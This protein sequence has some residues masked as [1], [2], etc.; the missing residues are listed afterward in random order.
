MIL[1]PSG[2][3]EYDARWRFP[4]EIDGEGLRRLGSALGTILGEEGRRRIVTGHDYRSYSEEVKASLIE[5]LTAAGMHV[6]DIGLALSPT[7]YFAQ[8]VLPGAPALAMVTASHN[9][10]GWTGVKMGAC[11]PLTFGPGEMAKLKETALNGARLPE[12]TGGGVEKVAGVA[13]RY[14]ADLASRR[15]FSRRLRVVLACGNGTAGFFAPEVFRRL[16]AE[17]IE[18]DC[19]P[20]W[21]FPRHNP[22]PESLAMMADLGRAVRE[23]GAELGLAFDGDGDRCGFTDETGA[24]LWADKMGLLL[25]RGLAE[26]GAARFI[27][28][29]K[30]T[31]LFGRDPVLSAA[32]ASVSYWKTG[33]SYMKMGLR[34][35]GAAAGFEKSGHFF[36][37]P[38]LGRGYD[39]GILSGI[40]VCE[41]L[42]AGGGR[43]SELYGSL[44]PTWLS[45]TMAPFCPDE[46]K[47]EAV[48]ALRREL[49]ARQAAGRR[50]AGR[51][52]RALLTVNGVRAELEDGGWILFRASSNRPSLVVVVESTRSEA[53]MRRLFESARAL[54][55]PLPEIGAFD[56]SL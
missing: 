9:E 11:A 1:A 27:V 50:I 6:L 10:N 20:D 30:S 51:A 49:E 31:G 12:K 4:E 55:A 19:R 52:I 37:G 54:L 25:A 41:M 28:D 13:E 56:Q 22:N 39:D 23:S 42:C 16:G 44:P 3:R 33:H 47:Y 38:P 40:V 7:A 14:I 35:T 2:F 17:V 53:D 5:G 24:L 8:S 45:P 46:K 21:T 15:R 18:Q 43:L 32:G 34:E 36:F 48:A 29:V 26:T